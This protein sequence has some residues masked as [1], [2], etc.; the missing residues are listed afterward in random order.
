MAP[1]NGTDT[2]ALASPPNRQATPAI[3]SQR[4]EFVLLSDIRDNTPDAPSI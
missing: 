3:K 4:F 2:A 1:V